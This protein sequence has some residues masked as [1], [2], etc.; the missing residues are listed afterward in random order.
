MASWMDCRRVVFLSNVPMYS[1]TCSYWLLGGAFKVPFYL[2]LLSLLEDAIL[3]WFAM[4]KKKSA[5]L[6]IRVV[7]RAL[8]TTFALLNVVEFFPLKAG[9]QRI[10]L[11]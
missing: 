3:L 8:D 4:G 11:A 6:R 9:L 7:S 10:A 2:V 5:R 1:P